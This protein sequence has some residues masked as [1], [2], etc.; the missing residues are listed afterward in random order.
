MGAA[1]KKRWSV[2]D[3]YWIEC[4]QYAVQFLIILNGFLQPKRQTH[5]MTLII[6]NYY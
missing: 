5:A 2:G 6:G 3:K 1:T 4:T